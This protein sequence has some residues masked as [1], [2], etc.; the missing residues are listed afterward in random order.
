VAWPPRKW[1][2]LSLPN[3]G[4]TPSG[5]GVRGG[6]PGVVDAQDALIVTLGPGEVGPPGERAARRRIGLRNE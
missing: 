6:A 5:T 1:R 2:G 3:G 4:G